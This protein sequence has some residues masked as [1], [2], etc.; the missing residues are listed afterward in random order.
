MAEL[1]Q[2]PVDEFVRRLKDKADKYSDSK[3]VFFIGAGCSISSK[4]P[5]AADL[6]RRWLPRLKYMKT[7]SEDGVDEWAADQYEGYSPETAACFYPLIIRDL[8]PEPEDQQREIEKLMEGKDPGF[9]Y[10]VLAQRMTLASQTYSK[11]SRRIHFR[12]AYTG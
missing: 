11:D 3:F 4:I 7:E 2:C 10:S 6:V 8:L 9:G 12:A 1:Q 5:A